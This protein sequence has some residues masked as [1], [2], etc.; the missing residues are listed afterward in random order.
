MNIGRA[1]VSLQMT[2]MNCTRAL[3]KR[4]GCCGRKK[5][6]REKEGISLIRVDATDGT[7]A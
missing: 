3:E 1:K 4:V 6:R 7:T 2:R 5:N